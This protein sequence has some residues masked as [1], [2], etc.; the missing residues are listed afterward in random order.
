MKTL[1]G[2]AKI[3][4]AIA[5][6]LVFGFLTALLI[7]GLVPQDGVDFNV[8]GSLVLT[9]P[10]AAVYWAAHRYTSQRI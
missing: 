8:V 1:V 5:L 6:E 2:E 7:L 10:C 3:Y 9:V 4:G